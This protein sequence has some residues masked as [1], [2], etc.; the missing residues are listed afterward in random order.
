MGCAVV[1][2]MPNTPCGIGKGVTVVSAGPGAGPEHLAQ[3]RHI[4]GCLGAAEMLL[5]LEDGRIRS[6]LARGVETAGRVAGELASQALRRFRSPQS[7]NRLENNAPS[8]DIAAF[9]SRWPPLQQF[10]LQQPFP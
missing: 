5:A 4:F 9:R 3:A 1:R 7:S 6:V 8:Y 2:A 10:R